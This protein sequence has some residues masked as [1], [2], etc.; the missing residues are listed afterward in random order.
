MIMIRWVPMRMLMD[1]MRASSTVR[2]GP[3]GMGRA[4]LP[5]GAETG[6]GK[7]R[8]PRLSTAAAQV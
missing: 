7:T 3:I 8:R 2:P 1:V 4:G 5:E 6:P